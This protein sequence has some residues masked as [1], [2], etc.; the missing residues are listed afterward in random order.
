[1]KVSFYLARP[2]GST[3]TVIYCR[4]SYSGYQMKYFTP[5]SIIPK[6]WNNAK[7]KP[8]RAKE[9]SK[10]PEYPEFNRRLDNIETAI[11]NAIRT[12]TNDHQGQVPTPAVLKPLIDIAVLQDGKSEKMTFVKYFDD[13][14]ERCKAGKITHKKTGKPL[15][16]GTI[17]S[18]ATT[19]FNIKRYITDTRD[20]VDF[21]TI[22]F[23]FYT[24]F[25]DY[26]VKKKNSH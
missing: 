20:K 16:P 26:L 1:M 5:E 22:D 15:T 4:I 13:Y 6:Y 3:P 11:K 14:I 19:L 25:N 12:Y 21:E 10:F 7:G 2:D 9:T 18:Y 17:K 23:D 24:S 8:H